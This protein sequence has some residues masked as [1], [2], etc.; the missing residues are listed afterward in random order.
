ASQRIDARG[1]HSPWSRTT[2]RTWP[3]S[4]SA[5]TSAPA[6]FPL[7]PVVEQALFEP[8]RIGAP[9][10]PGG[11]G[12]ETGIG[13]PPLA[14]CQHLP[15]GIQV[16]EAQV[17]PGWVDVTG[18][19][20]VGGVRAAPGLVIAGAIHVQQLDLQPLPGAEPVGGPV[21][22]VPGEVPYP[23]ASQGLDPVVAVRDLAEARGVAPG[24]G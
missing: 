15:L 14:L 19:A 3:G 23:G 5:D 7:Q 4:P 18:D 9:V 24:N 21:P 22:Q 17:D 1:I 6:Q 20:D 10:A 11:A 13:Q 16:A 8:Q 2:R 12:Q